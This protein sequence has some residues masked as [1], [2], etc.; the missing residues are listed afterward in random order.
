[1]KRESKLLF[2]KAVNSLELSME[3]HNRPI[4]FPNPA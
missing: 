2:T 4:H 3:H 1:M